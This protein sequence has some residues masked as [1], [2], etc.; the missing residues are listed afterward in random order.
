MSESSTVRHITPGS[1]VPPLPSQG[2][3]APASGALGRAGRP[4]S[5]VDHVADFYGAYTDAL[6]DRGRGQLADAL[7]HHY[8]TPELRRSLISWEAVHDRDGLLRARGVPASWRV[9]YDNS[10]TGHCWSRVTLVWE[11]DE[12]HPYRTTRLLVRSDPATRR[13]CGIRSLGTSDAV[14]AT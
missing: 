2:P 9:V 1:T 6:R 4:L 12:N 14:D 11:D 13:I 10:G 8:L 3:A 7:R 5:A